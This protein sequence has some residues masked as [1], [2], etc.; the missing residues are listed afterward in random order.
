MVEEVGQ[1]YYAWYT[2]MRTIKNEA[3][4]TISVTTDKDTATRQAL[5]GRGVYRR[6]TIRE[7]A[8]ALVDDAQYE[9]GVELLA[10][11]PLL[12]RLRLALED[13]ASEK[14]EWL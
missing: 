10:L 6:D 7:L 14:V 9:Q 8:V 12:S 3:Y 2:L 13:A 4:M 1:Y 5:S 11:P